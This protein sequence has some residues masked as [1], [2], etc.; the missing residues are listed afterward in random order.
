MSETM[1]KRQTLT[2]SS[3]NVL[4]GSSKISKPKRSAP[5]K[6]PATDSP[7]V[8]QTI[9]NLGQKDAGIR[10]C[11][12]CGMRFSTVCKDDETVHRRF[13]QA[14][15]EGFQYNPASSGGYTII[16]NTVNNS[17]SKIIM[18]NSEASAADRKKMMEIFDIVDW[19]LGACPRTSVDA[20]C[21]MFL[22]ISS[23]SRILGCVIA[24]Q[25]KHAYRVVPQPKELN[26]SLANGHSST[27][28]QAFC[29]I[30]RIWVA[31][32]ARRQKIAIHLLGDLH[33]MLSSFLYGYNFSEDDIAFS[34]PTS[35]GRKL[36]ESYCNRPDF[37][38]YI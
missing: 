1:S 26:P 30:S 6:I 19:E 27:K 17:G 32:F 35:L 33:F 12:G 16:N 11:K 8:Q 15:T 10:N 38:V 31:S 18:V 5:K 28:V 7:K 36:A 21:Q 24:E 37:L 23:T 14:A 4:S 22:Y 9:L 29:G 2:I 20:Q 13:H 3:L 25:I 34:Q